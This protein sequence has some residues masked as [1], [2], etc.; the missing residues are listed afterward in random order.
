[1]SGHP[2]KAVC[3]AEESLR[4]TGI[5]NADAQVEAWQESEKIH[6]SRSSSPYL[7]LHQHLRWRLPELVCGLWRNG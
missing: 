2:K 3:R 7:A 4:Q 1:M 5:A 6:L